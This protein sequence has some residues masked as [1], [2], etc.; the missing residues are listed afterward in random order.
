MQTLIN[1]MRSVE[2]LMEGCSLIDL[3]EATFDGGVQDLD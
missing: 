1:F 2:M 3:L